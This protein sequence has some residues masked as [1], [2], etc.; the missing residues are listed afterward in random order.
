VFIFSTSSV[1]D[2]ILPLEILPLETPRVSSKILT[3]PTSVV[4]LLL[5]TNTMASSAGGSDLFTSY[6]Q[7]FGTICEAIRSKVEK[8]IP[9]QS[10]GN[11]YFAF[12]LANLAHKLTTLSHY[13]S[14][15]KL[16]FAQLKERSMKLT[17]L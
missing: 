17:K 15:E 2:G 4:T 8:Q 16:L 1:L 14:N 6:E 12:I 13:Q 10:G 7:D 9:S 5:S 3:P 11:A